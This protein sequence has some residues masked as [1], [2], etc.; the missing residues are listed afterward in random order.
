MPSS[1]GCVL[2]SDGRCWAAWSILA[3]GRLQPWGA[4]VAGVPSATHPPQS[5]PSKFTHIVFIPVMITGKCF[6]LLRISQ[7]SVKR[8]P[9][10]TLENF[11]PFQSSATYCPGESCS[12]M[13]TNLPLH[14]SR[15]PRSQH[16]Q[17]P[18][19]RAQSSLNLDAHSDHWGA[20]K[21]QVFILHVWGWGLR[22]CISD[23]LPGDA[24]TTPCP[25]G[26]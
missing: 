25:T 6:P 17:K 13:L 12:V 18:R 9:K 14:G 19:H 26:M 2:W 7:P 4:E 11:P 24:R 16:P 10:A 8:G 3:L 15:V 21:M 23:Q 1:P 20:F 5:L 22:F